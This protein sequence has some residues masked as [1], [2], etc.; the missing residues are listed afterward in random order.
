MKTQI[1][2]TY[3][4]ATKVICACGHS[5]AT[6]STQKELHVEICSN[7]HPFYTGTQKLIDTTGT[8]DKFKKRSAAAVKLKASAKPKKARKSRQKS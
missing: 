1:H 5:F 3:N 4:T 8:V 2:P 7:C 6:G